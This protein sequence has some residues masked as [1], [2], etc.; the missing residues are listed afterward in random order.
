VALS[1]SCPAVCWSVVEGAIAAAAGDIAESSAPVAELVSISC[2]CCSVEFVI[3]GACGFIRAPVVFN[4]MLL[5]VVTPANGDVVALADGDVALVPA[6]A[7]SRFTSKT[8]EAFSAK[9]EVVAAERPPVCRLLCSASTKGTACGGKSAL[10]SASFGCDGAVSPANASPEA[11]IC[12]VPKNCTIEALSLDAVFGPKADSEVDVP[13]GGGACP[14]T[15]GM[16][17]IGSIIDNITI[18]I[19]DVVDKI[20][21][22]R[23]R[24]IK[25]SL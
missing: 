8:D 3:N 6:T 1:A 16:P 25:L 7:C 17:V 2:F 4:V 10:S 22:F 13:D 9:A 24:N 23:I 19:S 18:T 11:F 5:E 12:D 14:F 21:G 20:L 15:N